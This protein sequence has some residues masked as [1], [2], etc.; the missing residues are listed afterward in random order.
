MNSS[1]FPPQ[2]ALLAAPADA[3]DAV[4]HFDPYPY[5]DQLAAR[6]GLHF[7]PALQL[8][9][10]AS[11]ASVKAVLGHAACRV[12][13]PAQP[14]PAPIVGGSAGEVFAALVRMNDGERHAQPK[15]ALQ[16]ALAALPLAE[17]Q[18]RATRLGRQLWRGDGGLS[19]W[20]C[21]VPVTVVASLMG[22][23]AE[24]LPALAAWMGRFVACLSP[25]SSPGQLAD[26]HQCARDLLATFRTLL[27]QQ[28][29]PAPDTL[30]A[31]VWAEAQAAGWDDARAIL[32]NL[33]GLLSQTYE[34]SAGL[35]GNSVVAL[36]RQPE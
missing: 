36:V 33:V 5:Y 24:Q 7:D 13:P 10:A 19:H 12:R 35:L 22:F 18:Q 14:V 30:L 27:Q 29:P 15:L 2:A 1:D 17:A 11:A 26:A 32:A 28:P 25:L 6:G 23:P 8:W 34:A 9:V 21:E 4:G 16:R 3:L 31:L 20:L